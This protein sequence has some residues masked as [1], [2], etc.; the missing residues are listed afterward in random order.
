MNAK[1]TEGCLHQ[2]TENLEDRLRQGIDYFN[3]EFFFEAHDVFEELWM[4]A[5]NQNDRDFFHGLVNLATGFYHFRMG[6][7]KGMQSQLRKGME[8]LSGTVARLRGIEVDKL[9]NE[10]R[11][12][13]V[14]DEQREFAEPLPRIEFDFAK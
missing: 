3:R 6:N 2:E 5:R 12:Y 14:A 11:C 10:V 1:R 4:E 13:L 8:K 9:L 7:F